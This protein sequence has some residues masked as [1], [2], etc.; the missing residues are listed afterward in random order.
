MTNQN[1]K[2]YVLAEKKQAEYAEAYKNFINVLTEI[3][4]KYSSEASEQ[5]EVA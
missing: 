1:T 5:K 3:I 4:I 2:N